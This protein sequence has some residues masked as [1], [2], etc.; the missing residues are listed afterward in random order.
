MNR[1]DRRR[2]LK[3]DLRT[4]ARGLDPD[5]ADPVEVMALMR[6][7]HDRLEEAKSAG[8]IA[9]LMGFFHE[10]VRAAGRKA[11][12]R[13]LAC[14]MGCSHC[15]HAYVSAK[16]PEV[17]FVKK[18]LPPKERELIRASV[19]SSF[20]KSGSLG[21]AERSRLSLPCPLL[22]DNACQVYGARPLTCQMAASENAEICARAFAPGAEAEDIPTFEY[23]IST[24]RGYSLALAGA[25]RRAGLSPRSYELNAAM[26]RV[27]AREDA[28]A[29]WLSG[30]DV[31]AGVPE[32]SGGDPFT[33]PRNLRL[34]QAAWSE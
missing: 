19:E 31:F 21:L 13:F 34:Y 17:L 22:K 14:R 6:V 2:Q 23:Y 29:A 30:E 11:P 8:S 9:P 3:E 12:T 28:E 10:N 1:A 18:S 5:R 20:A 25:L 27:L 15:C 7:L 16:A 32:D 4:V 24:R 26:N 33:I